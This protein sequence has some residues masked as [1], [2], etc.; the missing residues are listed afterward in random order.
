MNTAI[1]IS[2]EAPK[3][4]FK[5]GRLFTAPQIDMLDFSPEFTSANFFAVVQT[6]EVGNG[7]E[8]KSRYYLSIKDGFMFYRAARY[9]V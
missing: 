1:A 2:T 4:F 8:F 5:D 7:A 6:V 3:F 9:C